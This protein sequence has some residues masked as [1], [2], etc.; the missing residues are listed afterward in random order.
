MQVRET[1]SPFLLK[2]RTSRLAVD[3]SQQ[4]PNSEINTAGKISKCL[5][6]TF[7]ATYLTK[8]AEL[9]ERSDGKASKKQQIGTK[10]QAL[11]DQ[12]LAIETHIRELEIDVVEPPRVGSYNN[13]CGNCD[14]RG[15]R[16]EGNQ[17]KGSCSVAPCTTYYHC[18]QKNKH[19]EHFQEIKNRKKN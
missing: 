5:L 18:G 15:H 3:T 8:S 19:K 10:L 12:K 4:P 7:S 1:H 6:P 13:I 14:I 2:K 17:R 9:V 16:S 11:N